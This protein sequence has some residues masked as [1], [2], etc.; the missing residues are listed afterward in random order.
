MTIVTII[1]SPV[2]GVTE[3]SGSGVRA[4]RVRFLSAAMVTAG[5]ALC[6]PGNHDVKFVRAARGHKVKQT[7][8]LTQTLEQYALWEFGPC[9]V[10][11]GW[12]RFFGSAG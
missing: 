5:H 3:I 7:H 11:G 10:L 8:G 6:V 1:A 2:A 4:I 12:R 9:R